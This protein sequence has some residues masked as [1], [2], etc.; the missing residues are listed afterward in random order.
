[1]TKYIIYKDTVFGR[2]YLTHIINK[3]PYSSNNISAA[4]VCENRSLAEFV[5]KLAEKYTG[6]LWWVQEVKHDKR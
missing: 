4:Q 3:R 1:M 5:A 6:H 2:K